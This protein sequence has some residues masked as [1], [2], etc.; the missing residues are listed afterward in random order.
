MAIKNPTD[1]EWLT[2]TE[3][4]HGLLGNEA[5]DLLIKRRMAEKFKHESYVDRNEAGEY[6]VFYPDGTKRMTRDADGNEVDSERIQQ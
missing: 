1:E 5:L 2:G 4:D 3:T 6:W